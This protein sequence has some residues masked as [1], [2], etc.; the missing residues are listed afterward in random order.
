M[1]SMKSMRCT[2][3]QWDHI[4]ESC[5][6]VQQKMFDETGEPPLSNVHVFP[7]G[8]N[9]YGKYFPEKDAEHG[10]KLYSYKPL[11]PLKHPILFVK[12]PADSAVN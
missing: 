5:T 6:G 12:L 4:W 11:S 7:N 9:R 8:Y 10:S 3:E 1:N 2:Q